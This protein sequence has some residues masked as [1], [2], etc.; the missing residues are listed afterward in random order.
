MPPKQKSLRALRKHVTTACTHCRNNKVKREDKRKV[1]VRVAVGLLAQRVDSLAQYIRNAG[2]PVPKQDEHSHRVLKGV[3]E[4]LELKCDDLA[5][6]NIQALSGVEPASLAN[7]VENELCTRPHADSTAL[8]DGNG[9]AASRRTAEA[10]AFLTPGSETVGTTSHEI[11]SRLVEGQPSATA[12]TSGGA[13]QNE[14]VGSDPESDDEVTDQ[15]S[16][17]L[18]RLQLTNDGQLRYFGSLSNLTLLDALVGAAPRLSVHKDTPML[19]E[20]ANLNRE[21]DEAFEEHLLELFFSWQDPSMHVIH[22]DTFWRSR[23]QSK[24]EGQANQYYSQPLSD[25]MCALGAAYESKYHPQFVV[26]PRSL[27]QYFGDRAR[28]LLELELDC[29]SITTVQTLVLLSHH[30]AACTED[31]RGWLYS[32]MA[33]RLSLDLGLHLEMGPYI[34]KGTISHQDAE[35]RRMIFWGVYLNEQ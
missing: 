26:F 9:T 12:V 3:L 15:F 4:A 28:L 10:S 13:G 24:H 20:N 30:E 7:P 23:A 1:P 2:L 19:L 8:R 27:A 34:E 22:P 14:Q 18:G 6:E 5:V 17:R 16:C 33:M 31:T 29:P 11:I 32:G 35:V 21:P 25:A